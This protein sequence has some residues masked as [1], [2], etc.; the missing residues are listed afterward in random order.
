MRKFLLVAVFGAFF[1]ALWVSASDAQMCGECMGEGMPCGGMMGGMKHEGMGMMRGMGGGMMEGDHPMMKLLMG[2]NLDDQ[3]KE[4]LRGIKSRVMKERIR[5]SSDLRIAQMEQKELLDKDPVDIKAVEA[6]LKQIEALKTDMHLSLIKAMEDI[7][8]KLTPEQKK[9]FRAMLEKGPMTG[10]MGTM[11]C[12][13]CEM[14]GHQ[15][16]EGKEG[17]SEHKHH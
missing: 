7:K 8:A 11:Q 12:A 16:M 5:R 1:L 13:D 4:A 10:G 6:K 17:P 9:K 14:A 3:Q 2:L 15:K